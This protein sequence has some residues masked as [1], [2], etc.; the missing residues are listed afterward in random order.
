MK[1]S[2]VYSHF[3]KYLKLEL[4]TQKNNF[5]TTANYINTIETHINAID[6]DRYDHH[7]YCIKLP[8]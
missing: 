1:I 8:I 4:V 3:H 5:T 7:N 2:S 6:D